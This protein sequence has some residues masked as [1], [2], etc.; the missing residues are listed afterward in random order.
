M[1]LG[2]P[3]IPALDFSRLR[4]QDGAADD[5]AVG[6]EASS[7][8]AKSKVHMPRLRLEMLGKNESSAV[9]ELPMSQQ[10]ATQQRG[11]EEGVKPLPEGRLSE[12]SGRGRGRGRTSGAATERRLSARQVLS[13][14]ADAH[15]SSKGL[16]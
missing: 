2:A 3:G 14:A 4:Q 11:P 8:S 16:H 15:K 5:S 12:A 1:S 7:S 10:P 9:P 13:C 6:A